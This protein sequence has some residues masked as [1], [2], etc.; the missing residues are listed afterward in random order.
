MEV[1]AR[2]VAEESRQQCAALPPAVRVARFDAASSRLGP[3]P[4][5]VHEATCPLHTVSSVCV[6]KGMGG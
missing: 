2:E 6:W 5:L 3:L 4:A 1:A